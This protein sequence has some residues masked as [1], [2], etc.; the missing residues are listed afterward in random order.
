[1]RAGLGS[2]HFQFTAFNKREMWIIEKN[3]LTVDMIHK[4]CLTENNGV[5]SLN[6]NSLNWK[7]SL[8]A[9]Y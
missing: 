6:Y 5:S 4:R 7:W 8:K 3:N 9:H 1:M 2:F